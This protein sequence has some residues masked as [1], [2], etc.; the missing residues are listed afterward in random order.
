MSA[1]GSEAG[2]ITSDL[3]NV[4]QGLRYTKKPRP[5]RTGVENDFLSVG[6]VDQ[7]GTVSL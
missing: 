7:I 1:V 3:A 2:G 6:G 4:F 5:V